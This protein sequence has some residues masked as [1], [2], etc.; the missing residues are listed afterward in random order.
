MTPA[1]K[2]RLYLIMLLVGGIGIAATFMLWAFQENMNLYYEPVRVKAGDAPTNHD[3]R[4]GGMV[5]DG[6]IRRDEGS[7]TVQFDVTDYQETV[8]V[9]YTGILPDLFREGQGIITRGQLDDKG[10]FIAEE[11]LAKHDE[12]YMPPEVAASLKASEEAGYTG[13]Q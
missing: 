7:L 5:V 6:S 2:R 12:N 9:H 8:T 11:V 10:D 13:Q 1:R 3:F 4:M